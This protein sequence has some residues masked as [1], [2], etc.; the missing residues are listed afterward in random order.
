MRSPGP[1]MTIASVIWWLTLVAWTAAIIAPAA[2]AMSAFTS[3]PT[4]D[5]TT[6]RIES[7]FGDDTEA[8]G[9]FIAGYVTH[10]VFQA[11][12]RVQ[13]G[14]AVVGIVL[15]FLRRGAPVGRLKS[16]SRRF[17]TA[18][19]LLAA[20]LLGWYLVGISPRVESTLEAW[21]SAVEAGDRDAATEAYAAFDPWH[22]S[23]ER[24]MSLILA[25]VLLTIVSSGVG[26]T[27]PR[28]GAR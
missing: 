18:T 22:R 10:P 17:A 27:P 1:T 20:A 7:F 28:S 9:R 16:I 25:A 13:T 5:L 19:M 14:C 26:S 24:G 6:D 23:A 2:T 8:A 21:R 11:S 3:L 12:D 15:L 4:M